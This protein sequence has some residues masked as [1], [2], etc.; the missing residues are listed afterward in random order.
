[1]LKETSPRK[2]IDEL[3]EVIAEDFLSGKSKEE[4]VK[5]LVELGWAQD[6]AEQVVDETMNELTPSPEARRELARKS[7]RKMKYGCLWF[8]GG[9]TFTL[10]T[11]LLAREQGGVYCIAWGAMLFGLLDFLRGLFGWIM[12]RSQK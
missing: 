5:H 4:M 11:Y 6:F 12:Y 7:Q 2:A 1:M 9:A 10:F 8:L 3:A